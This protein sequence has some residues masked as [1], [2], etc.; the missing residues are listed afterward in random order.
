MQYATVTRVRESTTAKKH[1]QERGALVAGY[2]A[3]AMFVSSSAMRAAMIVALMSAPAAHSDTA[4]QAT[5]EVVWETDVPD[6]P[7][8]WLAQCAGSVMVA[9]PSGKL[10]AL[11]PQRGAQLWER[12]LAGPIAGAVVPVGDVLAVP[13][14]DG[15]LVI[16]DGRTGDIIGEHH[17]PPSPRLIATSRGLLAAGS[18]SSIAMIPVRGGDLT[19]SSTG[20]ASLTAA[21]P[22][23]GVILA[24]FSNGSLGA[25][26]LEDGRLLW[27]RPLGAAMT[28]TPT[29]NHDRAWIGADDNKLHALNLKRNGFGKRWA[30]LTGGDLAGAQVLFG[31][32]LIFFSYDTYV[33]SVDEDNGHLD[34]K[35]RLG[36]RPGNATVVL[37]DLLVVAPLNSERLD[38]F[39]LP[40]GNQEAPFTL[41][42]GR[43]RFVTR[44][45]LVTDHIVI[46]A[47]LYGQ[48]TSRIIGL[49]PA[50]QPPAPAAQP[51][52]G[53][54][55]PTAPR[56]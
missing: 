3:P 28:T 32:R 38:V 51:P 23:G 48:D 41:D 4:A 44:P 29:C 22:C 6:T 52:A 31:G 24:G 26:A 43:E 49:R 19:W 10:R 50:A 7:A 20:P 14:G 17:T 16:L 1:R 21:G 40:G 54:P 35:A 11:E 45:V 34:W 13:L 47:A 33:Y 53:P 30:F 12:T 8:P 46:A 9:A 27:T 25:I 5:L 37:D 2:N 15:A 18:D 56:P 39:R 55:Q 42:T 36:R